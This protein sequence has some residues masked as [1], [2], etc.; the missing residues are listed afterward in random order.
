M[1]YQFDPVT[2][3]VGADRLADIRGAADAP[4]VHLDDPMAPGDS[5]Q[6]GGAPPSVPHSNH[7]AAE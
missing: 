1:R 3:L 6:P 5:G 7:P 2:G 4:P